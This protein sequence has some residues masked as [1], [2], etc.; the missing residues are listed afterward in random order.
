[1]GWAGVGILLD[2]PFGV[3]AGDKGADGVADLIDGLEDAAV[4]DLLLQRAEEALDDAVIRHEWRCLDVLLVP[5]GLG[6]GE[7]IRDVGHREH[8]SAGRPPKDMG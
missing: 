2:Q 8:E 7:P 4:H 3:V 1:M 5:S 6:Y